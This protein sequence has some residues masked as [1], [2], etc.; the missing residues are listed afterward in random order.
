M[1]VLFA[2]SACHDDGFRPV[3]N[4]DTGIAVDTNVAADTTVVDTTIATDTQVDTGGA[5]STMAVDTGDLADASDTVDPDPTD[6]D[7]NDT[8]EPGCDGF[9]CQ[10]NGNG[11]CLDELCVEGVD[12]RICTRT[13]IADCPDGFDC[14]NTAGIGPDP[15]SI[16]V[17]RHARLCRPCREDDECVSALDGFPAFCVDNAEPASGRSCATSCVSRPCPSGYSCDSVELPN[18]GNAQLCVPD[19]GMC[20]CRDSWDGKGYV[21]DCVTQT[22]AGGCPGTRTCGPNGLTACD[23]L[24]AMDEVCN[25]ID[26]NC[27]GEVDN[28]EA[29]ACTIDNIYG[30]C[31]G[32]LAC[33]PNGDVCQ[34]QEPAAEI[35]DGEDNDCDGEIDEEA[36]DDGLPCTTDA[37]E[38]L[39]CAHTPP[40]DGCVIQGACYT[41]G[42]PNVANPCEICDPAVNPNGF[43]Q[44]DNTCVIDGFCYANGA[45]NPQSPCQVCDTGLSTTSWSVNPNTC[46]IGNGCFSANQ[47]NPANSCQLCDPTQ[48][49][50]AWSQT[51]SSCLIQ[52]TCVSQGGINPSNPC[53][54]CDATQNDGG[55]TNRESTV[56]CNDNN[57]CSNDDHCDGAGACVGDTSCDD[58]NACTQDVC[59]NNGC[60][61]SGVTAGQ[62]RIG[63]QCYNAGDANP[64][65]VCQR[66][67]PSS[68]QTSWSASPSSVACSDGSACTAGDSCDGNGSC[69]PGPGCDDGLSCTDN[70]CNPSV[71]CSY[72]TQVGKCRINDACFNNNAT[73]PGNVC[74]RCNAAA[75]QTGWSLNNGASCSDGDS[76]S[77]N[78]VCSGGTC[79]G[80]G[81]VQDG[82]ENNDTSQSAHNAGS[83]SDDNSDTNNGWIRATINATLYGV[84]DVDWYRYDVSDDLAGV[85]QPR[86]K[87]G[88][89]PVGHNYQMCMWVA[90]TDDS[91]TPNVNCADDGYSNATGFNL[92][93]EA[94]RGCCTNAANNLDEE[95]ILDSY[96]CGGIFADDTY[97]AYVKIENV[98]SQWSCSPNYKLELGDD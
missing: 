2:L 57:A 48:S 9:G 47:L 5:D 17:P 31:A 34:G 35:C 15:I 64:Q 73:Q 3:G 94:Y 96:D 27:D 56:A 20:E 37:C 91:S 32:T 83:Y 67:T 53:Q 18:G 95:I 84:G 79:D 11:D 52:G 49:S 23:G 40:V 41:D 19:S 6:T 21:S 97:R 28:I 63:G 22:D 12:G 36:C 87:L 65:N 30:S 80:T 38:G 58:G 62:C 59:T 43:S 61:N 25:G 50:S 55:W 93:G 24:D 78:D 66:C 10:C 46:T 16:C 14:V 75:S 39:V 13:C 45:F 44:A 54:I 1:T 90:C 69:A 68:S 26:D 8:L 85:I 98:S 82:F 4:V 88:Q 76:C 71:G 92:G 74:F 60:D 81:S 29:T 89:I 51:A 72:P 33:G 77:T 7:D 70:I 42:Q 86:A